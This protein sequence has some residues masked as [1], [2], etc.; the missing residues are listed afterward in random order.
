MIGRPV[1]QYKSACLI[2]KR[3]WLNSSRVHMVMSGANPDHMHHIAKNKLKDNL[4][5][6]CLNDTASCYVWRTYSKLLRISF[7]GY[8]RDQDLYVV[9]GQYISINCI[10]IYFHF[11]FS[12]RGLRYVG[13]RFFS[14]IKKL[15]VGG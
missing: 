15:F 2:S 1:A 13:A 11:L 9:A 6:I 3:R 7:S 10:G 8:Y 4:P 14:V 12:C 5:C